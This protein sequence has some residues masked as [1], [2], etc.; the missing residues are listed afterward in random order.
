MILNKSSFSN[1]T[2]SVPP[3]AS[4]PEIG[5]VLSAYDDLIENNRRRIEL[6]EQSARLLY[7]EW[8]VHLRFPGHEHVKIVDGV[9][10]GWE[11]K[12]FPELVDFKEG[13][14]LR[15]HQYR[16]AGIPFLNIRTFADDEIDL[17]KAKCIDESEVEAR[18]QHFLLEAD[19]H[20][21]SSSGTLGRLVTIRACHLPVMLNTSLIRMRPKSN[22]KK[23]FLKAYLKHGDF[24]DQAR[25]MATGAAQLN[26]GPSHLKMMTVLTPT[27][28]L[29]EMFE[30]HAEPIYEQIKDLLDSNRKLSAARDILLPRL[31]NGEIAV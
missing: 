15:N 21:V 29:V 13:P 23:W 31:M 4:W 6:L 17:S 22:M 3:K 16:D 8:F 11:R 19:D 27:S 2:L 28:S 26:Y 12:P 1:I 20:V 30:D 9:P 10:E 25:S 18:Y 24:I 5:R 14:G 7:K